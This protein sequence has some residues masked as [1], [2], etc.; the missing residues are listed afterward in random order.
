[1]SVKFSN[2]EEIRKEQ[3]ERNFIIRPGEVLRGKIVKIEEYT[4]KNTA[5]YSLKVYFEIDEEGKYYNCFSEFYLKND[6]Y[7]N[8]G[9]KYFSLKRKNLIYFF[10]FVDLLN[11]INERQIIIEDDKDLDYEQFKD[12]KIGIVFGLVEY[13]KDGD[14]EIK[15]DVAINRFVKLNQMDNIAMPKVK[16]LNGG[17]MDYEEYM[18][19]HALNNDNLINGTNNN[20]TLFN[21][22]NENNIN[23][24][25]DHF[26]P[27]DPFNCVEEELP[28]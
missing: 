10:D 27:N 20:E 6:V 24:L 3:K 14:E 26:V 17:T 13:R 11:E 8:C 5:D 7:P 12:L 21:D 28:F 9:I 2:I 18:N 1:M 4:S 15:C 19:K 16:L 25:D 22:N 23:L